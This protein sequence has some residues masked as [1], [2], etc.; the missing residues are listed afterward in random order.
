MEL[1]SI[2]I[3]GSINIDFQGFFRDPQAKKLFELILDHFT[4][5]IKK[6]VC[7]E[8]EVDSILHECV[9]NFDASKLER[10]QIKNYLKDTLKRAMGGVVETPRL[11]DTTSTQ[12]ANGG[13]PKGVDP[14]G[15]N[16]MNSSQGTQK[17]SM[18]N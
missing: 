6:K 13:K 1:D 4:F 5:C 18:N 12:R 16:G 2:E 8:K 3:S 9:I 15:K 7:T 11:S 10:Q 14:S 17:G